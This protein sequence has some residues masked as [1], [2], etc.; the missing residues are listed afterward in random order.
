MATPGYELAEVYVARKL[1]KDRMKIEEEERAKTEEI[2]FEVKNSGGCFSSLFKKIHRSQGS[3]VQH[4]KKKKYGV[5]T[6]DQS[7]CNV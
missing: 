2:G 5:V 4:G 3:T 7:S 6:T 1:H